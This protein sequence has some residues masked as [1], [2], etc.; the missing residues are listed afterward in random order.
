MKSIEIDFD[1][2]KALFMRR[3]SEEVTYNDVLRDLLGLGPKKTATALTETV[4]S[5]RNWVTKGVRF[6]CGTEFRATY[7]GQAYYGKVE[8]GE[9]VVQNKKYSS[10]SAAAVAITN[11]PVNGWHFW[12]CRVPGSSSWKMIKTLRK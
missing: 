5:R 12:E 7:K 4:D 2:E 6:P 3:S 10:P 11:N 8:D 1:V 9:L